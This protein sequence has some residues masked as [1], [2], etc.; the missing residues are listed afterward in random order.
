MARLKNNFNNNN[1]DIC[2]QFFTQNHE[3]L[4]NENMK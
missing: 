1:Y 3:K 2:V 4:I